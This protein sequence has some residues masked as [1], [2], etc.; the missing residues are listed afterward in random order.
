MHTFFMTYLLLIEVTIIKTQPKRI[1][2]IF[3]YRQ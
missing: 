3:H 2:I 1:Y